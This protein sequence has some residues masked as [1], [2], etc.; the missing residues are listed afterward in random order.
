MTVNDLRTNVSISE[1]SK[2]EN[3]SR[4][5]NDG[6]IGSL[7]KIHGRKGNGPIDNLNGKVPESSGTIRGSPGI[8]LIDRKWGLRD[9]S[10]NEHDSEVNFKHGGRKRHETITPTYIRVSLEDD[11]FDDIESCSTEAANLDEVTLFYLLLPISFCKRQHLGC[12]VF[13]PLPLPFF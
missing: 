12:L 9:G 13:H 7:R 6:E 2:E 5:E 1:K 3:S 10:H 4:C 11:F 8:H